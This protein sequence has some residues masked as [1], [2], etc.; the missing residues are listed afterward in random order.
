MGSKMS[1]LACSA[2]ER[3]L[4]RTLKQS[5]RSSSKRCRYDESAYEAMG[6]PSFHMH[7]IQSQRGEFSDARRLQRVDTYREVQRHEQ[8]AKAI[9]SHPYQKQPSVDNS[10]NNQDQPTVSRHE[11]ASKNIGCSIEILD[12]PEM[13]TIS[14]RSHQSVRNLSS[15]RCSVEGAAEHIMCT[16]SDERKTEDQMFDSCGRNDDATIT[17][18]T[19]PP[20]SVNSQFISGITPLES[21]QENDDENSNDSVFIRGNDYFY[22]CPAGYYVHE[23]AFINNNSLVAVGQDMRQIELLQRE[24]SPFN[25]ALDVSEGPG[26]DSDFGASAGVE[27]RIVSSD[28]SSMNATHYLRHKGKLTS[29]KKRKVK[30]NDVTPRGNVTNVGTQPG[31]PASTQ[32]STC[33]RIG[34]GANPGETPNLPPFPRRRPA[35][36]AGFEG[37]MHH[38]TMEWDPYDVGYGDN[39]WTE[40]V[41]PGVTYPPYPLLCKKQYWV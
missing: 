13:S 22:D 32:R 36:V 1:C 30:G 39:G 11:G 25:C 34:F 14:L 18:L 3:R 6:Q 21:I 26:F 9:S 4:R 20:N 28:Y 7:R 41:I 29:S 15:R 2:R 40:Y 23:G 37:S 27:M 24:A 16:P 19:V 31:N 10:I 12:C 8:L 38:V 5:G 35:T 17:T 33:R